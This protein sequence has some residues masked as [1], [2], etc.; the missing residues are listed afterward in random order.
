MIFTL[1]ALAQLTAERRYGAVYVDKQG[2]TFT[3]G[4]PMLQARRAGKWRSR[5]EPIDQV[6]YIIPRGWKHERNEGREA[7]LLSPQHASGWAP[8]ITITVLA[9]PG[10]AT[11]LYADL[12]Q[13]GQERPK[14]NLISGGVQKR[15]GGVEAATI[16]YTYEE[17]DITIVEDETTFA[18]DE[19]H[20]VWVRSLCPQSIYR[21]FV[22]TIAKTFA[23]LRAIN[24][25]DVRPSIRPQF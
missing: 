1:L 16:R 14:F 7:M 10:D 13:R 3:I 23:S 8:V 6:K 21:E 5:S 19:Q 20:V 9:A 18:I 12:L 25:Q 17:R 11:E 22:E 24:R 4:K 15:D 2:R